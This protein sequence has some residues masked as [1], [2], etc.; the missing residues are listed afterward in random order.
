MPKDG[1][2]ETSPKRREDVRFL[3]GTGRYADDINLHGHVYAHFV[4]SD[5]A[6]GRIS[7][8]GVAEAEAMPAV[9]KVFTARISKAR[10]AS[11]AAG[12]SPRPTAP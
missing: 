2:I 11:P 9:L 4:R 5:V 6:H 1:G 8:I 10:A 12:R 7:S 3:T